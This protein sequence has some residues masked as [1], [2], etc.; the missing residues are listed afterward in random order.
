MKRILRLYEYIQTREVENI[1]TD[2]FYENNF[3][4]TTE[5]QGACH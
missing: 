5:L 2:V 1:R 4:R 3:V